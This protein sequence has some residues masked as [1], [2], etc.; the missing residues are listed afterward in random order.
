[1]K[2]N[3][4]A[5]ILLTTLVVNKQKQNQNQKENEI[6]YIDEEEQIYNKAILFC[7]SKFWFNFR[8]GSGILKLY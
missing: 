7:T 2:L 3:I 4:I 5:L 1:M 8:Q 6:E